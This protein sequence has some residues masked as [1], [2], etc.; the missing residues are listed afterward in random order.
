MAAVVFGQG[1]QGLCAGDPGDEGP[2]GGGV[3]VVVLGGADKGVSAVGAAPAGGA[4]AGGAVFL[5]GVA[6]YGAAGSVCGHR[7]Q[8]I[9]R[10]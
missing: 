8:P 10:A 2:H 1:R 7:L 4:F 5:G 9:E 6:A 3:G